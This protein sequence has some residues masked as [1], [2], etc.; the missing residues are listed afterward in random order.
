MFNLVT[1]MMKEAIR[2][3]YNNNSAV[4]KELCR[5]DDVYFVNRKKK[6]NNL[7]TIIE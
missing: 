6:G 3:E 7:P 5:R 4:I 2:K 1:L